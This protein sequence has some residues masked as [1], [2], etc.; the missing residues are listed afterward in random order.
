[1]GNKR[2]WIILYFVALAAVGSIGFYVIGG[3]QWS[4]IDSLYMTILTLSTVGY[5]E[6]HTLTGAGKIWSILIIIFGVSGIGALI[7]T[8]NEEFIQLEL[9][10]KN[11][12]MKTISKL[13]NHYVI[14]GYGRMGAVIAKELQ[15]KK[16]EFVIIENNEQKVEIIRSKGM[17]CV[18][19]DATSEETLQDARVDKAAGV[20]VV[21]DTD[22]DNLFVTMSMKT[23]NPDLFIL[24]RCAKEDNQ[25]KLIR[26]G[27]NKVV[28][29]YTAGGHR[30]AE[31]LLK[32]QVEDSISVVSP[33]HSD[34]NLT[35]DEISLKDLNQY[36][37]VL[38]K[39]SNIREEFDVMIVGIIKET[40]E[41]IINPA[42]DI[43]LSNKYTI[44]L[45]G[46]SDKMDRFKA[47]L[48]S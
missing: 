27:A 32:P 47:E 5:A 10:R 26:A 2:K 46:E 34:L 21:L 48:P 23:T 4:W 25:S 30:M 11:T 20:A 16:L 29:P 14:C 44:L 38:I 37:G 24:S 41:S 18:N 45:M 39:D 6:V 13:K 36:D 22:Q 19:G 7:R 40:G 35:L 1:M 28:N 15:E 3:D 8:L 33:K 9:F 12:M 17:F 43:F 42:P 31:I